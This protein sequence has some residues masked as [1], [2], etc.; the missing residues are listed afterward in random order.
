[1]N[2]DVLTSRKKLVVDYLA[3]CLQ[4][5]WVGWASVRS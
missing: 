4:R 1:M 3:L 2:R 5:G